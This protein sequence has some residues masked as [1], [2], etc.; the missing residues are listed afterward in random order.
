MGGHG[1]LI[2]YLKNPGAYKCISAFAPICHPT[3]SPWGEKAFKNYLKG[4]VEEGK[5]FDATELLKQIGGAKKRTLSILIDSGLADN[6]YQQQQLLPEHFANIAMELGYTDDQI[7][8]R[9]HEG[10]D[11]SCMYP[12][13]C[14][15]CLTRIDDFYHLLVYQIISSRHLL[16]NT[17]VFMQ[18]TSTVYDT[19]TS[20][21]PLIN[22]AIIGT[23]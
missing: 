21:G 14:Y 5:S 7:A 6:F 8:I 11:H 19:D 10:Y 13:I 17:S 12:F 2:L 1:A 16:L 9:L 15:H 3:Q 20:I 22:N 4:G 18:N 23:Q